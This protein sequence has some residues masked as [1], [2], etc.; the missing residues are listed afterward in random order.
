MAFACR[1]M[2]C[3]GVL[4]GIGAGG[5]EAAPARAPA[6]AQPTTPARWPA[7]FKAGKALEP[8]PGGQGAARQ[9]RLPKPIFA[10]R[11]GEAGLQQ[12]L[13]AGDWRLSASVVRDRPPRSPNAIDDPAD[14]MRHDVRTSKGVRLAAQPFRDLD[15]GPL[16]SLA[17][18]ARAQRVRIEDTAPAGAGRRLSEMRLGLSLEQHW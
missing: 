2:V 6:P 15:L 12:S 1:V 17:L 9:F 10:T 16:R 4:A 11:P 14:R 5:A 8:P 3:A 13:Y 7:A 18:E